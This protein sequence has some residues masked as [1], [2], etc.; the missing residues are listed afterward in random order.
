VNKAGTPAQASEIGAAVSAEEVWPVPANVVRTA[1]G[2]H[3][4][5][6]RA[7]GGIV[8]HGRGVALALA[9]ARYDRKGQVV[10]YTPMKLLALEHVETQWR[11]IYEMM[12]PG[13]VRRVWVEDTSGSVAIYVELL[14][15][16]D[17]RSRKVE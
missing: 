8:H 2:F 14:G 3:T 17:F 15:F 10:D 1:S 5:R 6:I 7:G 11:E 4:K 12:V 13:E 9:F 16:V